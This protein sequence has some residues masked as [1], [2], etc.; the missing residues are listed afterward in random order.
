METKPNQPKKHG[1]IVLV[2]KDPA[3]EAAHV[4]E[5]EAAGFEVHVCGEPKFA[6][7]VI[8]KKPKNWKP[9]FFIVEIILPQTSGFELVRR[10]IE[11]Y[12]DKNIPIVMMSQHK[13]KEDELEAHNAGAIA[14]LQKPVTSKAIK[15]LIEKEK[16]KKLKS[17][18]GTMAFD[19]NYE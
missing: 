8:E 7:S 13:S 17:E 18:I 4:K 11:R 14:V 19:I 10:I 3:A 2:P 16:M 5:M 9:L 15:D 1:A 6:L 12:G